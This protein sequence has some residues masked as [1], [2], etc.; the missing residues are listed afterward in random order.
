MEICPVGAGLLHADVSTGET[1]MTKLTDA[2]RDFTKAP[3]KRSSRLGSC[4]RICSQV[5]LNFEILVTCIH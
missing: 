3:R 5:P 1:D 2:F 4:A